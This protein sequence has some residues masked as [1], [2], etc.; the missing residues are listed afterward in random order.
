MKMKQTI[1]LLSFLFSNLGFAATYYVDAKPGVNC[2]GNYSIAN[3][4]CNG[5]DGTSRTTLGAGRD[6]LSSCDTLMVRAGTYADQ[7]AK[8]PVSGNLNGSG[9]YTVIRGYKDERPVLTTSLTYAQMNSDGNLALQLAAPLSIIGANRSY[10]EYRQFTQQGL[11]ICLFLYS[12]SAGGTHHIRYVDNNCTRN[13]AIGILTDPT[14][15]SHHIVANTFDQ[16]G[17]GAPGYVPGI[18][19]IYGTGSNTIVEKNHFVRSCHGV[20]IYASNRTFAPAQDNVIVRNNIFEKMGRNDLDPWQV[21]ANGFIPCG[22]AAGPAS[23]GNN[24]Q[25]YNNIY[26]DSLTAQSGT[27]SRAAFDTYAGQDGSMPTN[28]KFYNNTIYGRGFGSGFH[29]PTAGGSGHEVRNNIIYN[30][31][32]PYSGA[33]GS[34]TGGTI[35]VCSHNLTSATATASGR[36][37]NGLIGNPFFMNAAA[38]DFRLTPQSTLAIDKGFNLSGILNFDF[39]KSPRPQGA[40]F[41]IG[42]YEFGT[43]APVTI[44]PSAPKNLRIN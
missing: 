39:A 27:G 8:N 20:A 16:I 5:N 13:Q 21:T 28:A 43:S 34:F 4:A 17:I 3:R 37:T 33:Y 32:T 26:F 22:G 11:R 31:P 44:N 23:R 24:A 7:E 14:T 38:G 42:A 2:N 35:A 25:I 18:N 1:L 6:L 30:I 36:C 41:D 15:H 19:V 12:V 10:V 29:L 9:C 40:G